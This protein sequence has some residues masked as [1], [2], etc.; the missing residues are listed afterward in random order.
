MENKENMIQKNKNSELY[1]VQNSAKSNDKRYNV[2]KDIKKNNIW[3]K[4]E[5]C[6]CNNPLVMKWLN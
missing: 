4:V 1:L 2:S 6:Y 3:G 5:F